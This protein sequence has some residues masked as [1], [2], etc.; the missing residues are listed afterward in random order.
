MLRRVES[1][2]AGEAITEAIRTASLLGRDDVA[3]QSWRLAKQLGFAN[4][5]AP[6]A[7]GPLFRQK[8]IDEFLTAWQEVPVRDEMNADMLW[9]LIG[10]TLGRTTSPETLILLQSAIRPYQSHIDLERLAPHL[11]SAFGSAHV[12]RVIQREL[13][14]APNKNVRTKLQTLLR[15]Y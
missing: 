1:D 12:K 5:A 10:P 8:D 6:A 3:V 15:R 4:S 7:L 11:V 13:E 14:N 2:Q 9:H